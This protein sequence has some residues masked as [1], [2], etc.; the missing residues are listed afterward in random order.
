MTQVS[1]VNSA[2]EKTGTIHL[3][4]RFFGMPP[5]QDLVHE[6]V[7][8]QRSNQRQGNASTKTRG[9]VQGGGKKPFRQKGTGRA[10]A[11]SNRSPLWRGGG[12]IFGPRPRGYVRKL[13]R[14]KSRLALFTA[15]SARVRE[16]RV[17]VTEEISLSEPKTRVLAEILKKLELKDKT[18]ILMEKPSDL[19]QRAARNHPAVTLKALEQLNV[20]DIMVHQHI[21]I[22]QEDLQSL[23]QKFEEMVHTGVAGQ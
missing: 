18:L 10:R 9:E 2:N 17:K 16:G 21:L 4:D 7:V 1:V 23:Q 22:G 5:R 20:Y 8:L 13:T 19:F 6:A 3:D 12:T 14:K 11:G 15:L